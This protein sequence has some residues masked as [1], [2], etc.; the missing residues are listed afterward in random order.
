MD[1]RWGAEGRCEWNQRRKRRGL[2]FLPGGQ[3][4]RKG[5]TRVSVQ[6]MTVRKGVFGVKGSLIGEKNE[7]RTSLQGGR[8]EKSVDHAGGD[9]EKKKLFET[10]R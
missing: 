10:P 5:G 2:R 7:R 9:R 1:Q 8:N 3:G 6:K 4:E